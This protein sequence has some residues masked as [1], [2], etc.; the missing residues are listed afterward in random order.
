MRET[1][2]HCINT[3]RIFTQ[4][5]FQKIAQGATCNTLVKASYFRDKFT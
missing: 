1:Q 2:G 4:K 5:T 3:Y